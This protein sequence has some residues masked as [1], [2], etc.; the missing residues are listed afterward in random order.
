MATRK[1][2]QLDVNLSN[3]KDAAVRAVLDSIVTF[4]N[5]ATQAL[6]TSGDIKG[7]RIQNLRGNAGFTDDGRLF[8]KAIQTSEGGYYKSA[9]FEGRLGPLGGGSEVAV[10]SIT[11]FILGVAGYSQFEDGSLWVNM[12]SFDNLLVNNGQCGFWDPS[13]GT[14]SDTDYNPASNRVTVV[15][16]DQSD[17]NSY[18]IIVFYKE[19]A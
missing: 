12:R 16:F 1:K 4:V 19:G 7:R 9:V 2:Q 10:H 14:L 5:Q 8:A 6:E 17:S 15:N 11:G 13:I 3:V 18:R